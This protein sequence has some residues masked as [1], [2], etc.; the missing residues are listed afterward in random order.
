MCTR[1]RCDGGRRRATEDIHV[2][3]RLCRV[4]HVCVCVPIHGYTHTPECTYANHGVDDD[5]A[6][7]DDDGIQ[8]PTRPR[9]GASA[10]RGGGDDDAR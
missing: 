8:R 1:G 5:D 6:R 9:V 3:A 10:R 7:D 2:W 4:C